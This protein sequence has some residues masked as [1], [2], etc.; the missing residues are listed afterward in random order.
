MRLQ[1]AHIP[2]FCPPPLLFHPPAYIRVDPLPNPAFFS[3]NNSKNNTKQKCSVDAPRPASTATSVSL[4]SPYYSAVHRH[5]RSRQSSP[6]R[7]SQ[8]GC[9]GC[10]SGVVAVCCAVLSVLRSS[11]VGRGGLMLVSS[12][13]P[14]HARGSIGRDRGDW[15]KKE[16]IGSEMEAEK[17]DDQSN[18][19]PIP[20]FPLSSSLRLESHDA[21][22]P[23]T[24]PVCGCERALC[25][26]EASC[27]VP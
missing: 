1:A 23:T 2:N 22:S 21:H 16:R 6:W 20:L 9:S 19:S 15:A 10:F 18:P 4:P 17:V 3:L 11:G 7:Q 14:C 24:I 8:E 13:F 27:V 12:G 5:G 25:E 26:R